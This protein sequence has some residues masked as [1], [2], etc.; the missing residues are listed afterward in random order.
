[1]WIFYLENYSYVAL[2]FSQRQLL[3]SLL[4]FIVISILSWC[5]RSASV[6][7]LLPAWLFFWVWML[8]LSLLASPTF[9][10]SGLLNGILLGVRE[11]LQLWL[12][13]Q[14][15]A[16]CGLPYVERLSDNFAL[17]P[18][19]SWNKLIL[20][21]WILLAG[22]KALGMLN[23]RRQLSRIA[24]TARPITE[25][26]LLA[27]LEK[28]RRRYRLRRSVALRSSG[29]SQQAFTIG[30]LR[31]LVFLP[32]HLLHALNGADLDA[33]LG[34]E[35]AH[36]KRCDDAFVCFQLISKSLLF[37]NPLVWFSG[38]RITS[39]RERC[40]DLLAIQA[41]DLSP[42]SYAESLLRVAELH[43]V[44]DF[45]SEV[46]AGLTSS[47]LAK[48]VRHVLSPHKNNF[49]WLPLL[50]AML[51]LPLLNLAL[52]PDIAGIDVIRDDEA[53]ALLT[54]LHAVPPM[55]RAAIVRNFI[56]AA[57][58]SCALPQRAQYHPGIDF[59]PGSTGDRSVRAIA[60]GEISAVI[61][62]SAYFGAL[63]QIN[64]AN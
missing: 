13:L 18:L 49:T 63:L 22:S 7:S 56:D 35:L 61:H 44:S 42:Q 17:L 12:P 46:A 52:M 36:I 31:P 48:R 54:E 60:D 43:H 20:G 29:E 3:L 59:V 64:H 38:Q 8:P 34:H 26:Q 24:K 51:L 15:L 53:K 45:D 57:N 32:E 55:P 37:F 1:M 5:W 40:C 2:A 9:L 21:V 33:I 58:T 50:A 27:A 23:Q 16:P 19:L 14:I 39:L 6:R 4:G 62:S 41:S 28:W 11:H 25:P 10:N 47:A 30:V